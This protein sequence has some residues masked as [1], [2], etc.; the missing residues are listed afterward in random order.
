MKLRLGVVLFACL[1]FACLASAQG[2][3]NDCVQGTCQPSDDGLCMKTC[4]NRPIGASCI[5]TWN[6]LECATRSPADYY[7]TSRMPQQ[8]EGSA[9]RLQ[10]APAVKAPPVKCAIVPRRT[11]A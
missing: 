8:T 3:C 6:V 2:G 1:A 7:F 11:A 4:C 5:F 10:Y 9:V